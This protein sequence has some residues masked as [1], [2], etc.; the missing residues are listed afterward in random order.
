MPSSTAGMGTGKWKRGRRAKA[1]W[2]QEPHRLRT[3]AEMWGRHLG[4]KCQR[5]AVAR[6]R[7]RSRRNAHGVRNPK[8][9][10][11]RVHRK[12]K[13]PPRDGQ[14]AISGIKMVGVPGLEPGT[15]RSRSVWRVLSKRNQDNHPSGN[16]GVRVPTRCLSPALISLFR[17]REDGRVHRL[18]HRVH[19]LVAVELEG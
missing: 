9:P 1:K 7:H 11:R 19:A 10:N 8:P 17:H 6:P 18:A 16:C 15:S 13:P 4:E 3:G 14:R 2:A 5:P 12:R